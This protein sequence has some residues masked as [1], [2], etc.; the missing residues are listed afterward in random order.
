MSNQIKAQEKAMNDPSHTD[1]GETAK[2]VKA[3]TVKKKMR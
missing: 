1:N 3:K 2:T